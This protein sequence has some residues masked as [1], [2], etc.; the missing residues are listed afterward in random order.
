MEV[1]DNCVVLPKSFPAERIALE[2]RCV[3]NGF[4]E[5]QARTRAE[6]VKGEGIRGYGWGCSLRWESLAGF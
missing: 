5:T 3:L 1:R 6:G 4:R 2:C